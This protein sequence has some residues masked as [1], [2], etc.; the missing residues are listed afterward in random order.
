MLR[1]CYYEQGRSKT[2]SYS[3]AVVCEEWFLFSNFKSWMEKQAWQGKQLDK[4]LLFKG[5]KIYSPDTCIFISKH[6]NLFL[7]ERQ[8]SRGRYLIGCSLD[9]KTGKFKAACSNPY[10]GKQET[11]GFFTEEVDAHQAWLS[12]KLEFAKMIASEQDDPRVSKALIER[13]EN[14]QPD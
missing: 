5:N 9:K 1:R 3:N 12:R 8:K 6:V 13:Y 2:E 4:D 7:T 14:Y 11:L 10:K